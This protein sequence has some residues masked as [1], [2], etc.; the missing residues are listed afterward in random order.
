MEPVK[1]SAEDARPQDGAG[2]ERAVIYR[3]AILPRTVRRLYARA[4]RICAALDLAPW[5]FRKGL[6]ATE[7]Q[8]AV[9]EA[10]HLLAQWYDP[11]NVH[12][13]RAHV[14]GG[15]GAVAHYALDANEPPVSDWNR[16]CTNLAGIAAETVVFGKFRSA[17]SRGDLANAH[18]RAVRL[19]A[20]HVPCVWQVRSRT[21]IDFTK[22]WA[23]PPP[24]EV[25]EVLR[26]CFCRAKDLITGDRVLFMRLVAALYAERILFAERIVRLCGPRAWAIVEHGSPLDREATKT[27]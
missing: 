12:I 4:F 16:A 15:N 2:P 26:T 22:M 19:V 1:S 23:E 25:A 20:A 13:A 27:D 18:A 5:A 7:M 9:H 6:V 11:F 8:T 14:S 3:P 21:V 17:D 24:R 10:G